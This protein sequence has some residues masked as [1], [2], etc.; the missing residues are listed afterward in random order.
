MR[1]LQI[2]IVDK[3]PEEIEV[4]LNAQFLQAHYE[5]GLKPLY[6]FNLVGQTK[7]ST[8]LLDFFYEPKVAESIHCETQRKLALV[9]VGNNRGLGLRYVEDIPPGMRDRTLIVSEDRLD[10]SVVAKYQDLGVSR[11]CLRPSLY[12]GVLSILKERESE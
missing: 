12:N 1:N 6:T 2:V 11:F 5:V 4:L 8:R 10:S 3:L 7:V 9:V